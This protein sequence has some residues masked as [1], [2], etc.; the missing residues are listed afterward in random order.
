M[1]GYYWNYTV[2]IY[3][4]A[5]KQP[6]VFSLVCFVEIKKLFPDEI[7]EIEKENYFRLVPSV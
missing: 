2:N 1:G 5:I 4:L 7:V 6:F 3:W